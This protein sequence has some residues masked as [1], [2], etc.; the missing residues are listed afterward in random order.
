MARFGSGSSIL[1]SPTLCVLPSL[2]E[3][4]FRVLASL[5]EIPLGAAGDVGV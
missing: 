5:R 4:H 1:T 2:R 3:N